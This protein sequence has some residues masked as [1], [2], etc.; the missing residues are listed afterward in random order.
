VVGVRALGNDEISRGKESTYLSKCLSTSRPKL[1]E[2]AM[3]VVL[4]L[5]CEKWKG[6]KALP[7]FLP[8]MYGATRFISARVSSWLLPLCCMAVSFT[9]FMYNVISVA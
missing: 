2:E 1:C 8:K 5:Y 9:A 6:E 4:L 3:R 7:S